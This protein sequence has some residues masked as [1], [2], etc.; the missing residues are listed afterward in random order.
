MT[1]CTYTYHS[2]D[3]IADFSV[4]S[5]IA[6]G[7]FGEVYLVRDMSGTTL[8]LKLLKGDSGCEMSAIS[9]LR[10]LVGNESGMVAI[11]HIG[12]AAGRIYYTMDAADN[13]AAKDAEYCP[14]TLENRLSFRGALNAFEALDIAEAL[15]S[16]LDALH[17]H[18]LVHRDLKP[19]NV[20]FKD[21]KPLLADFG[22]ITTA[23]GGVAG[24]LGFVPPEAVPADAFEVHKSRDFYAL[25][26]VLYCMLTNEDADRFPIL[27]KSY[28]VADVAALRKVWVRA[29]AAKPACRFTEGCDFIEALKKARRELCGVREDKGKNW[30]AIIAVAVSVALMV[31]AASL[32]VLRSSGTDKDDDA[33]TA[34]YVNIEEVDGEYCVFCCFNVIGDPDPMS[35]SNRRKAAALTMDALGKYRNLPPGKSVKVLSAKRTP[36]PER[37]GGLLLYHYQIPV[38]SCEDVASK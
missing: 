33:E 15:A 35:L 20:I 38:M 28:S 26:K 4:V 2:G 24:T 14:D 34:V 10:K 12:E 29:C 1:D 16:A 23:D 5:V 8:A 17:A 19:A 37:H 9:R 30:F 13:L 6:A 18:G 32:F 11:H 36:E 25:G 27:P 7:T 22:L 31:V 3:R 21:G